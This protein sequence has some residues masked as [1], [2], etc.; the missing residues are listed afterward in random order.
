MTDYRCGPAFHEAGH[1]VVAW[2]LGLP[3]DGVAIGLEDDETKGCAWIAT[4]QGH[5]S[6]IDRLAVWLAGIEAEDFFH[7]WTHELAGVS[8]LDNAKGVIEA[9][10]PDEDVPE[11]KIDA[12]LNA[13]HARARELIAGNE[14]RCR[15]LA[16]RLEE[17]RQVSADEF[18]RMMTNLIGGPGLR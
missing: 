17:Q 8:D 11:E 3:V 15:R 10:T 12:L 4:A 2:S 13:G 6:L 14:I 1:A 16:A 7:S 5:L 18:R 9:E